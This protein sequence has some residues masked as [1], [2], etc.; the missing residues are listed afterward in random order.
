MEKKLEVTYDSG[1]LYSPPLK[2]KIKKL[3]PKAVIPSYAKEGDAGMD[4]TAVSADYTELYEKGIVTYGTGLS[5]EIPKGYEGQI[6][7]RSSVYKSNLILSNSVGTIDSGYRGEIMFKYRIA[8]SPEDIYFISHYKYVKQIEHYLK[9][10]TY[11][12]GDRIGQLIIKPYPAVKF[13]EVE[14]LE[15]SERG[16]DGWGSSGK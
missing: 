2:I 13:I 12:V 6:R 3:D 8:L 16:T 7:P 11:K 9:E 4:L 14:E 1:K 5:L 15:K 10:K